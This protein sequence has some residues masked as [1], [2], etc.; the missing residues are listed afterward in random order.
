MKQP[1]TLSV[2]FPAYNE[3][4]N[5]Q[6]TV[7]RTIRVIEDS[8]YIGA[9]E[10]L[11]INDGSTDETQTVAESLAKQFATVRVINHDQ[12][13]GYGAALRTGISEARMDYVFFTDAD[14]QFDIAEL[15][16]LIVHLSEYPVVIGYRAPRK[17]PA[18]RLVNA[19]GWNVLNRMLFGLRVRDIDCAF[20]IFRRDLVQSLKLQSKGAMI[21]A[22]TL[23]R[24]ARKNIA[25]KEVPVSHLPRKAGSPTGANLSVIVRAFNE[26]ISLYRGELGLTTHKEALRFMSVGVLNTLLDALAYVA[27]TRGTDVFAHHLVAAKFFS[28]LA[29]TVSSLL[30]NRTWTFGMEGRLTAA[31]VIR[32]YTVTSLSITV[33]VAM[34]NL[35]VSFGMYDLVALALTTV[36]T[37]AANFTLSKFWVFKKQSP[38]TG[39]Q[40]PAHQS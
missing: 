6:E 17:D 33:N 36:V 29:G 19:W 39:A 14:L 34:M 28:F 32:F 5:I 22:E 12:N 15:Q 2:F 30:L 10:L 25:F 7:L 40:I 3:E 16:K 11:I 1:I 9:Y 26:M 21:S 13:R 35:L 4:K 27:L 37:F 23:I 24:L 20:K 8:P 18:M 31:E 38:A